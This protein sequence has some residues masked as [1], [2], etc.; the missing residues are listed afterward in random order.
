ML[1]YS[2]IGLTLVGAVFLFIQNRHYG[3]IDEQGILRDSL[4]LPIGAFSLIL[5]FALLALF[6]G[7]TVYKKFK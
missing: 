3:Y 5:G 1:K 6:A 2:G 4:F 7:I